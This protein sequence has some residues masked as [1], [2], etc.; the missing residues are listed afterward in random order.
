M[1]G[2]TALFQS[3]RLRYCNPEGA[4]PVLFEM[5][6]IEND[7]TAFLSLSRFHWASTESVDVFIQIGAQEFKEILPVL[8]GGMRLRLPPEATQRVISALQEGLEVVI[9]VD[10]FKE[11]LHPEQFNS[12]FEK[13][14]GGQFSLKNF[15]KGPF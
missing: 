15:L 3:S 4:C 2:D 13:F 1:G 8:E 11:K 9:L 5:L 14:T 6:R 7:L 12:Y 10:G